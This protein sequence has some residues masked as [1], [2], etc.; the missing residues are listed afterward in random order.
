MAE[1]IFKFDEICKHTDLRVSNDHEQI[2]TKKIISS[3]IIKLMNTGD[4]EKILKVLKEDM[5]HTEQQ[6]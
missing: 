3:H 4:K 6:K 5:I 1:K 2:S